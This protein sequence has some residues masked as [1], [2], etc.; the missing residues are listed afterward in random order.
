MDVRNITDAT[1]FILLSKGGPV[2]W[3]AMAGKMAEIVRQQ[4]S[5]RAAGKSI[6]IAGTEIPAR[7]TLL[8]HEGRH[9]ETLIVRA[10][11][12]AM[13]AIC[14]VEKR[15]RAPH[16]AMLG[17]LF[18]VTPEDVSFE[19]P[20]SPATRLARQISGGSDAERKTATA[21][22]AAMGGPQPEAAAALAVAVSSTAMPAKADVV[23][24][25]GLL[26]RNT[27]EALP[28]LIQALSDKAVR[29]EAVAALAALGPKAAPALPTLGKLAANKK[30]SKP[31]RATVNKAIAAIKG[32]SATV[33]AHA[34]KKSRAAHPT[35][36]KKH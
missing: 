26:A 15:G 25:L 18:G 7:I 20:L 23:A 31:F 35:H 2:D 33:P 14:P 32:K 34:K 16:H 28:P 36:K 29:N 5:D 17:T 24:A 1:Y 22:L 30:E 21:Q 9:F 3:E 19:A 8:E 12:R 13:L 4:G 27:A 11:D 6:W 10:R